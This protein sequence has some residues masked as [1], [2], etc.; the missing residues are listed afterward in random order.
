MTRGH[1]FRKSVVLGIAILAGLAHQAAMANVTVSPAADTYVT[2]HPSL[3]GTSSTHGS[4]PTL[5]EIGTPGFQCTPLLLFNLSGYAGQTVVG[6]A[7]LQLYV[8]S[9]GYTP[10]TQTISVCNELNTWTAA[11]TSWNTLPGPFGTT[12]STLDTETVT[13]DGQSNPARYVTW[14]IP[15]SA[16]QSWINNPAGNDGIVLVS[17]TT[18]YFEDLTFSSQEGSFSPLLTF[19]TSSNPAAVRAWSNSGTTWSVASNWV[20]AVPGSADVAQFNLGAYAFQPNLTA[21]A[22]VGALWNTGSGSL[23]IAGSTL[24]LNSATINGN[25][26]A[27]IEM[28]AGAGALTIS[29]SLALG[30]PQMWLN[31]SSSPLTIAGNIANAGNPLMIA[32]SG[33][34]TISGGLGGPAGLT[35]AGNGLLAM[36]GS[37]TYGGATTVNQGTLKV[38]F[39]ARGAPVNNIINSSAL[40][41]AGGSLVV[42]GSAGIANSQ[43]FNGLTVNAGASSLA[44]VSGTGGTATVSLGAI[45][46]YAGGTVDFTLPTSGGIATTQ[47]TNGPGV[48]VDVG[49]YWTAYATVNGGSTWANLSNGQIVGLAAYSYTNGFSGSYVSTTLITQSLSPAGGVEAGVVTFNKPGIT[50][51]LSGNNDLADAGGI[52]ITPAAIGTVISGGSMHPGGG[53][54]VV[55]ID[56]GTLNVSSA[57]GDYSAGTTLT[58]AGTGLTT[59]TGTN[60]YSGT[61]YVNNGAMVQIG[62]GGNTGTLGLANIVNNG[63]LIFSRSNNAAQGADFGGPISGAGSVIKNGGGK[64]IFNTGNTYSGGTTISAGTLQLGDGAANNGSVAG[65]IVNNAT[66]ALANPAA[67]TFNGTISG[68][69]QVVVLGPGP[70]TL[71]G[72]DSFTGNTVVQGGVLTLGNSA[73]LPA[74]GN[75]I[76]SANNCL[77][78]AAGT[79]AFNVGNLSGNGGFALSDAG[80]APVTLQVGGNGASSTFSGSLTGGGGLSKIGSGTFTLGGADTFAAS[81]GIAIS[82][83]TLA[84]PYGISHG[85]SAVSVP[86]GATFLAGGQVDRAVSGNG[87][88]TATSELIIGNAGQSGQFNQGGAP[89]GGGTLNVGGNAVVILSAGT[90]VLGSQTNIAA[91]GSLTA[92]NGIQLGNPASV[93]ATKVLN[94]TGAATING[95]FVNN[96]VVNGPTGGG[97]ELTFTQFVKGAGST[98]GNVEY[99]ASYLP[100]NS[101]NA[102]S[103]QN[104]LLDS[105]STLIM[106]LAGDAPGSGYDQLD[107][108]GL[109]TLNGTLDVALL[110]GFTPSVGDNFDIFDGSTTGSF[111][112]I[113]LPAL[114]GGLSWNTADLYSNGSISV[115]PEPSTIVLLAAGVVALLCCAVRRPRS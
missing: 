8:E 115:V 110:N 39:S 111:T 95:N 91:G 98:S 85:G 50:L 11:S 103:V 73:A 6:N 9:G 70:F 107:I 53:N 60:T 72:A 29:S 58:V 26:S 67:Q 3:G 33:S 86:A 46:R 51:T 66:L 37:N 78:F 80:N 17:Q 34:I 61:T 1:L 15:A 75:L 94:A 84:A 57:I 31:N 112:Q 88:V 49:S 100:S 74:N 109:A 21:A 52:L 45:T 23:A 48:L 96:G 62:I 25:S 108:S 93:D 87:T 24:T 69:G 13:Y 22:S 65:N 44:V 10:A 83:G 32:G 36:T 114:T 2:Q 90:A 97:Q 82:Q 38:D 106:E 55:L 12:G 18:A 99:Q 14:T 42:Q 79:G 81:G 47:T 77:A 64:L 43:S 20:G 59:V 54:G 113:D 41:F 76:V 92:I 7:T 5:Y 63:T 28:D 101:P 27:G 19:N 16:L 105:T 102:V 68:S 71:A 40:T 56:Y 104:V 35:K 89:G 30:V 4:D